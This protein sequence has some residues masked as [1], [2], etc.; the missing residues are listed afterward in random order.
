MFRY[1]KILYFIVLLFLS[2]QLALPAYPESCN[3]FVY[4]YKNLINSVY[5][6]YAT[7]PE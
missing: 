4:I 1:F 2:I 5:S 3:I 7:T 6:I